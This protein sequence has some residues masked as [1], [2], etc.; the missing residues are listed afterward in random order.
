MLDHLAIQAGAF[1]I[2]NVAAALNKEGGGGRHGILD[3]MDLLNRVSAVNSPQRRPPLLVVRQVHRMTSRYVEG[4]R[5]RCRWD[6][7]TVTQD[8]GA[9]GGEDEDEEDRDAAEAERRAAEE[10]EAEFAGEGD[11][12]EEDDDEDEGDEE[13]EE[14][15]EEDEE[16][17]KRGRKRGKGKRKEEGKK[18]K[19]EGGEEEEGDEKDKD[20]EKEKDKEAAEEGDDEDASDGGG[21]RQ[22]GGAGQR[23]GRECTWARGRESAHGC[24]LPAGP[25]RCWRLTGPR[26]AFRTCQRMPSR[27]R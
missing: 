13:D 27:R 12:E 21:L 24:C 18:R 20:K 9:M 15:E 5:A 8:V 6:V 11:E 3:T 4:A 19:R 25:W 7:C 17:G 14:D 2:G 10:E 22:V 23:H 16:K 26:R 1:N